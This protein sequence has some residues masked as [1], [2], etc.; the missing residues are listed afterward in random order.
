M[1]CYTGIIESRARRDVRQVLILKQDLPQVY[2]RK[3]LRYTILILVV[4]SILLLIRRAR[5]EIDAE[6]AHAKADYL[7][8]HN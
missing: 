2:L 3:N 7:V 4:S 1:V 6:K 5:D 8:D